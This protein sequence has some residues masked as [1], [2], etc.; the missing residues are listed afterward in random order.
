MSVFP[1]RLERLPEKLLSVD[2]LAML[3]AAILLATLLDGDAPSSLSG[4]QFTVE[5]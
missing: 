2:G 3:P 5:C 4:D 1:A